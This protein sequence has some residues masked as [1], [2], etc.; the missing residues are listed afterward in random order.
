MIT[1]FDLLNQALSFL[2]DIIEGAFGIVV[3]FI[4]LYL[5]DG[6]ATL[7]QRI[8]ELMLCGY[9]DITG[10]VVSG[11]SG[12]NGDMGLLSLVDWS[13]LG[14]VVLVCSGVIL[15]LLVFIIVKGVISL[16]HKLIDSIP[17]IG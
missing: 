11:L 9:D 7:M 5:P 3:S 1:L 14:H 4:A 13:T 16:A 8:P 15:F 2:G 10:E 6:D 17:V 12:F